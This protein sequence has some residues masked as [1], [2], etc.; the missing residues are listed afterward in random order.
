VG[1][2]TTLLSAIFFLP[3]LFQWLEDREATPDDHAV[4]STSPQATPEEVEA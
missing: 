3:A 1:I 2:G 4:P